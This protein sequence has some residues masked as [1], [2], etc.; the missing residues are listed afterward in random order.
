[1]EA[2]RFV[3]VGMLLLLT[4]GGAPS[5]WAGKPLEGAMISPVMRSAM[6][7]YLGNAGYA[8][9]LW[10]AVNH[11]YFNR[12]N[13]GGKR[14]T[15]AD[16]EQK[17]SPCGDAANSN[18]PNEYG[19]KYSIGKVV[20]QYHEGQHIN[21]SVDIRSLNPGGTFRF[22]L[23]V[24]DK[25]T[26]VSHSCFQTHVLRWQ[27][28]QIT[29]IP[30]PHQLGLATYTLQLPSGVSCQNCVIQWLW[31]DATSACDPQSS[32]NCGQ[33]T[34]TNC[35]DVQILGAGVPFSE[36]FDKPRYDAY[37]SIFD[38][39]D[40]LNDDGIGIHT[41]RSSLD[42][43]I[44]IKPG[45]G[46]TSAATSPGGSIPIL[47]PGGTP[48]TSPSTGGSIPIIPGGGLPTSTSSGNS[49]SDGSPPDTSEKLVDPVSVLLPAAVGTSSVL[50]GE[51]G[52]GMALI[53]FALF[54]YLSQQQLI[55][56]APGIGSPTSPTFLST[57]WTQQTYL[58][59]AMS[60]QQ[61]A[62]S[63]RPVFNS[64][65]M[66]YAQAMNSGFSQGVSGVGGMTF[67]SSNFASGLANQ[68]IVPLP[69]S[70]FGSTSTAVLQ[71]PL[72]NMNTVPLSNSVPVG[73]SQSVIP[74]NVNTGFT[75]F[76]SPFT[77]I[78]VDFS[79]STGFAQQAFLGNGMAAATSN[80]PFNNNGFSG[81]FQQIPQSNSAFVAIP[82]Q[83][84][85]IS[86]TLPTSTSSLSQPS[87][88]APFLTRQDVVI[89]QFDQEPSTVRERETTHIQIDTED[90]R[91]C[92]CHA[93]VFLLTAHC[94]ALSAPKCLE[95]DACYCKEETQ[96]S[97][98]FNQRQRLSLSSNRNHVR[99]MTSPAHGRQFQ[100]RFML[101]N[102]INKSSKT[103]IYRR[104]LYNDF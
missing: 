53:L 85:V 21:V 2:I 25:T 50:A 48:S 10:Q 96:V 26:K 93:R 3:T 43:A 98:T 16:Y 23:C 92:K 52:I 37:S 17:C 61:T 12:L 101:C 40:T 41:P 35:A 27:N 46:T 62:I 76:Q 78:P 45:V 68:A 5:V 18:R 19:G 70:A 47:L 15:D 4:V 67:P 71:Q 73:M 88:Q 89:P 11:D 29:Q 55:Q 33:Q 34:V 66:P 36:N 44:A 49:S 102:V 69:Q 56:G 95:D 63:R 51:T 9:Q 20:A 42:P 103:L 57:P 83:Q 104:C 30:S 77:N 24:T 81:S 60:F 74:T 91:S 99:K 14:T 22:S 28:T 8:N 75:T 90:V 54:M 32:T 31:R 72:V 38:P 7:A 1:M 94:H 58:N 80:I 87:F 84:S 13:C 65:P 100:R 86:G 97:A 39:M 82:S 64:A 79:R 6:W 59:P